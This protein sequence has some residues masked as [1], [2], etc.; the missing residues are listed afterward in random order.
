MESHQ[1]TFRPP[2]SPDRKPLHTLL[3]LD[4]PLTLY[5][6][7]SDVCN[8]RCQFCF[9]HFSHIPHNIMSLDLFKKIARDMQEFPQSVKM[10]HLHA[11]GEPLL[12]K[13]IPEFVRILKNTPLF[14]GGGQSQNALLQLQ[15]PVS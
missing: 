3:P 11:N 2:M 5:I 6:D 9:Q 7:P 8:F 13:H 4:S 1:A 10:V 12:N 15:T 14:G